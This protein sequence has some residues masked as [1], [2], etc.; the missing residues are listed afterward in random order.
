[1]E[2][3]ITKTFR[4]RIAQKH[5]YE[6][7][8][9]KATT[10]IPKAGELII[11]DADIT[12]PE[13][14]KGIHEK[15]RLKIGDGIKKVNDLDFFVEDPIFT[16]NKSGEVSICTSELTTA[17]YL[18]EW[19]WKCSSD[20]E[21]QIYSWIYKCVYEGTTVNE[22]VFTIED[23]TVTFVTDGKKHNTEE[24]TNDIETYYNRY[25]A[26]NVLIPAGTNMV[27]TILADNLVTFLRIPVAHFNIKDE[28]LLDTICWR[29]LFDNPLL[30]FSNFPSMR[31]THIPVIKNADGI[32]QYIYSV[33]PTTEKRCQAQEICNTAISKIIAK[34]KKLY[35]IY[36]GDTITID[37]KVKILKVI[38][39]SIILHGNLTTGK[40]VGYYFSTPY[41]VYD[42]RYQGN[43]GSYTLAFCTIARLYGIESLYMNGMCYV[44][45]K[46]DTD[47]FEASGGHAWVAVRISDEPYGEY[48]TDPDKWSCIDVY[49]DEPLESKKMGIPVELEDISWI[50][51]LD[52]SAISIYNTEAEA[53]KTKHSYRILDQL[54]GPLPINGIPSLSIPYSGS[55][56]DTWEE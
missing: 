16:L 21:K 24:I 28:V 47:G 26:D 31:S 2:K 13:D 29:V 49:W 35:N 44:D 48:P 25:T 39:D 30:M 45:T 9:S 43:C 14:V 32:C 19:G 6:K 46:P 17:P 18:N 52:M 5:D 34:I 22:R 53:D 54:S 23:K 3:I 8:W 38:H 1:M 12:A 51:F 33:I 7:N 15:P 27:K 4:T 41:S 11:Y 40:K 56:I 42:T 50:H 37:Q 10:F 20:S 55:S 36:P